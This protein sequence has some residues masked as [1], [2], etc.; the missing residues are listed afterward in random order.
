VTVRLRKGYDTDSQFLALW[1]RIRARTRYSVD[2]KTSEL[3]AKAAS[4][5]QSKMPA[6]ERPKVALTRSRDRHWCGGGGW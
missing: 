2:Y 5:I 6:I 4:R 1:E 3:I